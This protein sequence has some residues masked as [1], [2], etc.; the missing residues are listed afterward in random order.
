MIKKISVF[1]IVAGAIA[2]LYGIYLYQKP[3]ESLTEKKADIS[4]PATELI[5]EFSQNSEEANNK[6]LNQIVEI[7][8]S[9]SR[10]INEKGLIAAEIDQGGSFVI[11][12]NLDTNVFSGTLN[13]GAS[14]GFIGRYSGYIDEDSDFEI[15]GEIKLS[16]CVV[17]T[18]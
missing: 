5:N 14:Y 11:S 1:I 16:S 7:N 9:I 17:K 12:L 3:I 6:F 10:F 4:I 2:A 13:E 18:N 15:P 8:G